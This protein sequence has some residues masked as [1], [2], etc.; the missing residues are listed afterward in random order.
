M[1]L[2]D[3]I[4]IVNYVSDAFKKYE[5]PENNQEIRE[6][7]LSAACS[8]VV[9]RIHFTSKNDDWPDLGAMQLQKSSHQRQTMSKVGV[10]H[11]LEE[12]EI[13]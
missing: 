11:D 1:I 3:F 7:G 6:Q 5:S 2:S 9:T 8:L 4:K 13:E 10:N 12:A